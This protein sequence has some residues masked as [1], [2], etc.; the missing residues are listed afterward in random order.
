[1]VEARGTGSR[2]VDFGAADFNE[3]WEAYRNPAKRTEKRVRTYHGDVLA[4]ATNKKTQ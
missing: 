1:M 3:F 2:A 4:S